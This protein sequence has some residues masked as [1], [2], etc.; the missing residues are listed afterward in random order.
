MKV[1]LGK[2]V[3][4]KPFYWEVDKEKNPHLV[5]LGTSGSGKTETLKVIIHELT[6]NKVPS[7]VIDFHNEF[8]NV[9]AN[10][11][12]LREVSINPFEVA[13]NERPESV[14]YEITDIIKKLFGLGDIQEAILRNA[15]RQSYLEKGINLKQKGAGNS[16]FPTFSD[17]QRNIYR[18]EDSKNKT[19]IASLMSRIEPLIDLDIFET[20]TNID[21]SDLIRETT[22]V[23]LKDF[24]TE[25]VK[26]VIAEFFLNKLSYYLYSWD[27]SK[28]MKLY[29]VIDEAHRLMYDNSPLDRFLRESR[30]YG[31]GVILASQR[32]V[33][34]NETVLANVG[35]VMSFQCS[36]EKDAH[37]IAR[38][39]NLETRKIK[40]LIEPGLGY[41]KFSRSEKSEKVK[42]IPLKER[43]KEEGKNQGIPKEIKP[44][45]KEKKEF[46]K[47]EK[48]KKEDKREFEVVEEENNKG[49]KKELSSRE[50]FVGIEE[51]NEEELPKEED[52]E[53]ET[54]KKN[55]NAKL[56]MAKKM[57]FYENEKVSRTTLFRIFA[58]SGL[59]VLGFW[60]LY[61]LSIYSLMFFLIAII[62]MP[63]FAEYL[64]IK[65]ESLKFFNVFRAI[66]SILIISVFLLFA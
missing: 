7:L 24:P 35:G 43:L 48:Q 32:P 8:S 17:I 5:V 23:G 62:W 49:D 22:V 20:D 34:F 11:L 56:I 36:L 59:M 19:T 3:I 29:C 63:L 18:Q 61:Y 13:E 21:F 64:N 9:A 57:F 25:T 41:I 4:D 10:V 6:K 15:I 50:E 33:D 66:L 1:L 16:N 2:N 47:E 51:T 12:N 55:K 45:H 14:M 54:P 65:G 31:V 52:S 39:L 38:Q 53:K 28:N 60:A 42:V 27:R 46:K 44:T 30:K 58:L 40:N 26:A 37:Y